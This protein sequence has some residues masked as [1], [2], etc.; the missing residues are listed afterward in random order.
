MKIPI[1]MQL[2]E[3]GE[4][5][6]RRVSN[7]EHAT[8]CRAFGLDQASYWFETPESVAR[9]PVCRPGRKNDWPVF[10][11]PRGSEPVGKM[12]ITRDGQRFRDYDP[13]DK[14]EFFNFHKG[15]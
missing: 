13:F 15:S 6:M 4:T 2:L 12:E 5:K 3:T 8:L 7:M 9:D 10:C 1:I 14:S 11:G